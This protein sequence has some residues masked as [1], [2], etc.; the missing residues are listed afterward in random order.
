MHC[1]ANKTNCTNNMGAF[2]IAMGI[3]SLIV[4]DFMSRDVKTGKEFQTIKEI[5]K[6]MNDNDIGSVIIL[7]K[8]NK[9]IAMVT[10]R[11]IVNE[12][13]SSDSFAVDAPISRIMG[14]VLIGIGEESSIRQ[15]AETMRLNNVRRLVVMKEGKLLG[16]ITDKDIFRA[17]TKDLNMTSDIVK[18]F[19]E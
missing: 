5:C 12:I 8:D 7:T 19:Y 11:D 17:L 4:S 9:P 6:T 2:R 10:E 14:R 13:G 18:S 1:T 16:V 15:A 3:D